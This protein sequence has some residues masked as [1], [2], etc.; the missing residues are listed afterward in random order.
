MLDCIGYSTYLAGGIAH[1]IEIDG[2]T[3]K[4]DGQPYVVQETS[5]LYI[6]YGPVG[7]WQPGSADP[8]PQRIS[9]DR[10]TGGYSIRDS[11]SRVL[12]WSR[13]EDPGCRKATR[14]SD[15]ISN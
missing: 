4:V 3:A 13:P 9:L 5:A 6:L 14:Y 1:H 8:P 12:D 2:T 7:K 11:E 15:A 10:I